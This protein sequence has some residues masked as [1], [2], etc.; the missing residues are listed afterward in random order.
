MTLNEYFSSLKNKRLAVIG[1]GVSNLP[2]V[3]LLC[4]SGCDVTVCDKR[5]AEQ[6]GE[7]LPR[8]Q[9]KGVK[10]CLGERY[11]DT[12]DFD[13]IF[14]T[15][16]LHPR[17]LVAAEANGAVITS[18]MELFFRFCPCRI[19][20]VSGSDG[21]TTTT[22]LI[23]EILKAAGYRVHLGGNIGQPLL[24][25]ISGMRPDDMV[26]LELSSFQLHSMNCCP[27]VA[28]VTNVSPN[29]LDVHPD[30][31]DYICAKKN[32]FRK[33]LSSHRLVLNA[34]N[35]ITADFAAEANAQIRFFSRQ[36]MIGNGYSCLDG[37][38]YRNGE[39]YMQ[40][41]E[42]LLPGTHNIEN[43]MAAFAATDDLADPEAQWQVA[44]SFT[45]VEHRIEPVRKLRGVTYYNDSIA[46]SPSRTIAG[47]HSFQQKVILIAGGRDKHVPFDGLAQEI[48]CHVKKL[49]LTGEAADQIYQAVEKAAPAQGGVPVCRIDDFR[50]AVLA[51][52]R[53][54]EEGDIVIL[55]PACTSFDRFKNFAERGNVFKEIVMSLE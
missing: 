21:K 25:E 40:A 2:L 5:S 33:Q 37:V 12:L 42:I 41:E 24:A 7:L 16:G 32:I 44:R 49:F 47:L 17:F 23:A 46:S 22:T 54:A 6:L 27:D 48:Q 43:M 38:I 29:H 53:A 8:F 4:D 26:V 55:S 9:A 36:R 51:A 30:Y 19:V 28:V 45:G 50:Q 20:A 1:L 14:R 31:N 39:A 35:G 10:F 11:L 34:D 52:S 13:V 15:P 3:E 18:E